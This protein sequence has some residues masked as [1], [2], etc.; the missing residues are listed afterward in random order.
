MAIGPHHAGIRSRWLS[1]LQLAVG[2][3]L[4][5]AVVVWLRLVLGGLGEGAERGMI[6]EIRAQRVA[7][8]AVVGVSL[9]VA[10]VLLQS[11][12]RNPL[13]SPDLLGLA[14]GAGLGVMVAVFGAYVVTGRLADPGVMGAGGAAILGACGTLAVVYSVSQRRGFVDPFSLVLVGVIVGLMCG[15][16]ITLLQH[17]MPDGGFASGRLLV[18]ALDEDAGWM[19]ISA[20]GLVTLV[21]AAVAWFI[22]PAMDR[23]ALS[24]DEATSVGVDLGRLRT[25]QF[26]LAGVL[27]ACAV[28]LAGP[29]GFVG[30]VC[31]HMVRMAAG[32]RHAGLVLCAGLAGAVMVVGGDLV[33]A[34]LHQARQGLGNFPLSVVTALIGGPVF[35]L[36]LRSQRRL[37]E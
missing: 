11:L 9:A 23:A 22:S 17:V 24:D 14:S 32:P 7:T 34:A 21:C 13:A 8:A 12:L 4:V 10:G 20:V 3:A 5:L 37:G 18:G 15:S 16:G 27:T 31:P 28:V 1:V 25:T 29:V 36:V 6:L 35:V 2:L 26:V 19:R 33:I 30:L